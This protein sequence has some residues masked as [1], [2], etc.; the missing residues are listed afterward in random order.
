MPT[1]RS[2]ALIVSAFLFTLSGCFRA[3]ESWTTLD[4][5]AMTP[6]ETRQLETAS[7]ARDALFN[8]L[9]G[10]LV[11]AIQEG[12][13]S[14]A[15]TVCRDAAPEVAAK[16]GEDQGVTIGRTSFRLRNP[17][18]RPPTWAKP[19]VDEQ[20]AEP[21]VLRNDSDGSLAALFP[22]PLKAECLQCHGPR[23]EIQPD[24]LEA[25]RKAYP[26]DNATGFQEG[27]LRG[28][29]HVRVPAAAS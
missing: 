2:F 21:V 25:L 5:S 27:E 4:Q 23:A 14:A 10:R 28:W 13:A 11:E 26:R 19:F 6:A 29:F 16:V 15:I 7:A 17:K 12:G 1:A 3:T 24:V 9:M 22:I 20:R 8:A 18:N